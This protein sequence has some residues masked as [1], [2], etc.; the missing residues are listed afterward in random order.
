MFNF[1]FN[2]IASHVLPILVLFPSWLF[3]ELCH[4]YTS[5]DYLFINLL[6]LHLTHSTRV[7]SP[8]DSPEGAEGCQ[9]DV[10]APGPVQDALR[11]G[12]QVRH[13]SHTHQM[14]NCGIIHWLFGKYGL[15]AVRW[16]FICDLRCL[17]LNIHLHFT[18]YILL[19][20][21]H[22]PVSVGPGKCLKMPR[23]VW[24]WTG[25]S[26]LSI[27]RTAARSPPMTLSRCWLTSGSESSIR[28]MMAVTVHCRW[29]VVLAVLYVS[30]YPSVCLHYRRTLVF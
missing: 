15:L 21:E 28:P 30:R 18:M 10:S 25:S 3:E 24:T 4:C 22:D 20:R 23:A 13:S 8:P 11:L 7:C 6:L 27:A 9:A 19:T 29:F 14:E 1:F 5:R 12:C 2:W 26:L 16:W 17:R